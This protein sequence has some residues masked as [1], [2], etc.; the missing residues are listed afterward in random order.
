M[1]TLKPIGEIQNLLRIKPS[2]IVSRVSYLKTLNI[3]FKVFLKTKNMFLQRDFV[4]SLLQKQEIIYSILYN[5]HI[6]HLAIISNLKDEWEVID[7]KQ[8]LSSIFEFIDNKFSIELEDQEIYFDDLPEDYQRAI[9]HK[10][11]RYYVVFEQDEKITDEDRI[12]WFKF[13]NFAGT[14]Q[15]A[16]HLDSLTWTY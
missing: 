16:Y 2:E 10:T 6:P 5:R 15:D 8:R 12:Q 4:W 9:T 14:P 7:G 13:I 11:L 1:I 3:D